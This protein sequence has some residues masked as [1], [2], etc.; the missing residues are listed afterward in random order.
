MVTEEANYLLPEAELEAVMESPNDDRLYPSYDSGEKRLQQCFENVISESR[1]P[2]KSIG[3]FA[4]R[5]RQQFKTKPSGLELAGQGKIFAEL[6]IDGAACMLAI[7]KF[8][9]DKNSFPPAPRRAKTEQKIALIS[10]NLAN[11]STLAKIENRFGS[12]SIAKPALIL[13]P[14]AG[15]LFYL[16]Q[17]MNFYRPLID[18]MVSFADARSFLILGE[19]PKNISASLPVWLKNKFPGF[20]PTATAHSD[21]GYFLLTKF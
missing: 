10:G 7:P 8:L 20:H 15:G 18:W 17:D 21:G 13:Y 5:F 11:V 16:P 4:E 2:F 3:G 6:E 9:V 12:E 19:Y 14:P 1:A